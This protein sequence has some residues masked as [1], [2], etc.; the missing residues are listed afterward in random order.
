MNAR[1]AVFQVLILFAQNNLDL[2]K[3]IERVFKKPFKNSRDKRLAFE[4]IYGVLRN[5]TYLDFILKKFL[6]EKIRVSEEFMIILRIGL[7]QLLYLD[8][9]PA[10][11]AVSESVNLAKGN[12]MFKLAGVVNAILRRVEKEKRTAMQ[13]PDDL[14]PLKKLSLQY[15]HPEWMIS[16]WMEQYGS[17]KTKKLLQHNNKR[18]EVF[19]RRAY[20]SVARPRFEADVASVSETAP[21][22]SGYKN[23]YYKIKGSVLPQDMNS[24]QA[25][26]CTVQAPS[27]GWVVAL[28]DVKEGDEIL[29]MSAA[30]GGKT[31]LLAELTGSEGAVVACDKNPRRTPLIVENAIRMGINNIYSVTCDGN[32]PSFKRTFDKVLLDAPCSGTGVVQRHPDARWQRK[33]EDIFNVSKLQREL[34]DSAAKLVKKGGV[35]V[36]STCSL[37]E[38]ENQEEVEAFL[39]RNR[40]FTLEKA[41]DYVGTKYTDRTGYL[42]ITPQ[43]HGLDGMFAARLVR[44]K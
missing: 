1:E 16:R 27:S 7:Y 40:E 42:V 14:A 12:K 31:T 15:S 21:L 22:A 44:K 29:D 28:L 10:H 37:E 18:A 34:L 35:L 25:G 43:D 4:I 30:P 19:V 20:R 3:A 24:F 23:L 13:L 26:N 17:A 8:R 9:V 5:Q 2:E 38:E 33:E 36:Y 41:T 6:T 39:K 11:A 32:A